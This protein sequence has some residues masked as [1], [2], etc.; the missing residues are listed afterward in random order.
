MTCMCN[1][2]CSYCPPT[3]ETLQF[4]LINKPR[5]QQDA[6]QPEQ[7]HTNQDDS[8]SSSFILGA[9]D[10]I[11]QEAVGQVKN[12]RHGL[13][14][15]KTHTGSHAQELK[16]LEW[17]VPYLVKNV[18]GTESRVSLEVQNLCMCASNDTRSWP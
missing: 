3:R 11:A 5:L 10:A 12:D 17:A 1:A 4:P 8:Y 14:V 15:Q 2:T 9:W 13:L 7:G 18:P 16:L 6:R